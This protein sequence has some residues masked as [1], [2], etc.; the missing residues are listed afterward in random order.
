MI[1]DLVPARIST[2]LAAKIVGLT[3]EQVRRRACEHGLTMD[4]HDHSRDFVECILQRPLTAA[5]YLLADRKLDRRREINRK[6]NT[7]RAN[8][9]VAA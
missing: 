6:Y 9:W 2:V 7:K 1:D 3:P 4:F 5:E 8:Q